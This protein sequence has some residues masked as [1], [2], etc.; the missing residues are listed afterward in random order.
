MN[1]RSHPNFPVPKLYLQIIN[2]SELFLRSIIFYHC[3]EA[4][5]TSE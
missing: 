5:I 4:M 1:G 3:E 2:A